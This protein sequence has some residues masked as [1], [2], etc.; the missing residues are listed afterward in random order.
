MVL[1]QQ[2]VEVISPHV[3]WIG[4]LPNSL[5]GKDAFKLANAILQENS[6]LS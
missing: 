5:A 1:N 6:R 2:T 3:I 4:V